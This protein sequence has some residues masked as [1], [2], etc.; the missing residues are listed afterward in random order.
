MENGNKWDMLKNDDIVTVFH[1]NTKQFGESQNCLMFDG[2]VKTSL[3]HLLFLMNEVPLY[4]KWM[5]F[6]SDSNY[7]TPRDSRMVAD[8]WWQIESP[9]PFLLQSRDACVTVKM[10]DCLDE[11]KAAVYVLMQDM[12]VAGVPKGC[13]P[14]TERMFVKQIGFR[15]QPI[16]A[17]SVRVTGLGEVDVHL[18]YM[19]S[20]L[21]NWIASHVCAKGLRLWSEKA[22]ELQQSMDP[23]F[24]QYLENNKQFYVWLRKRILSATLHLQ[25]CNGRNRVSCQ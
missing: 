12:E 2:I 20:F 24:E 9:F 19:P 1:D 17:Q 5:P 11:E 16:G 3:F 14:C 15:L 7:V 25:N 6:V 8:V 4:P 10:Y 21:I 22:A 23:K 18:R 13:K